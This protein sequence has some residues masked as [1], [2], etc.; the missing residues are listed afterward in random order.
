METE[1][2]SLL[3]SS[4]LPPVP[5]EVP[6]ENLIDRFGN[7]SAYSTNPSTKNSPEYTP[8]LE[9]QEADNQKFVPSKVP[10]I[11]KKGIKKQYEPI[12]DNGI[13]YRYDEDPDEYRKAR[14]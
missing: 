13:L 4:S 1:T 14:K 5:E 10:P 6:C 3:P 12:L 7:D 8:N 9:D 2:F 11:T